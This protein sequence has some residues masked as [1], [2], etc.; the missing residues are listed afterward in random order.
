L[1]QISNNF[2]PLFKEESGGGFILNRNVTIT[3]KVLRLSAESAELKKSS[4][5]LR[6]FVQNAPEKFCGYQRD[7][8][9]EKSFPGKIVRIFAE[10]WAGYNNPEFYFF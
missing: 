3:G 6:G 1:N 7:Q 10:N 4:R 2:P 8:R 5:R 9:E